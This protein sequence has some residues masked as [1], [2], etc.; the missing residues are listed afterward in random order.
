MFILLYIINKD[1]K[2]TCRCDKMVYFKTG[3]LN[4]YQKHG[5]LNHGLVTP[6]Y[7]LNDNE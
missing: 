7:R 4:V 6:R 1:T 3:S 5:H 2:K